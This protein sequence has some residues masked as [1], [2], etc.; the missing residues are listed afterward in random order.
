MKITSG[1]VRCQRDYVLI[2]HK[3]FIV[4]ANFAQGGAP[5]GARAAEG[6][7]AIRTALTAG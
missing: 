5:D 6:V 4:V 1:L 2:T 3:G 7:A